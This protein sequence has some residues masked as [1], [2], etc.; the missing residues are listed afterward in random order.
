MIFEWGE[1]LEQHDD[2][3]TCGQ[4]QPRDTATVNDIPVS[5]ET[6]GNFACRTTSEETV[7]L[8]TRRQTDKVK[9]PQL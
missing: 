7:L 5:S 1:A 3:A 9:S 8:D 4:A 2:A 6:F